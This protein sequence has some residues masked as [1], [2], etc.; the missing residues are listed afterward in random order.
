M[1]IVLKAELFSI[2][3]Q[4][5]KPICLYLMSRWSRGCNFALN[6]FISYQEKWSMSPHCT[7]FD[8]VVFL[9]IPLSSG[10]NQ[11]PSEYAVQKSILLIY[12]LISALEKSNRWRAFYI[13]GFI[14]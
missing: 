13:S 1:H 11:Y 8:I 10:V 2:M 12:V 14:E 9:D 3:H 7:E 6:V 5:I 4:L